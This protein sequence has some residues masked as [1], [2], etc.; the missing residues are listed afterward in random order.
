PSGEAP[1]GFP[2]NVFYRPL[3]GMTFAQITNGGQL[4]QEPLKREEYT[5]VQRSADMAA[6]GWTSQQAEQ[7]AAVIGVRNAKGLLV[8][9][10]W[11]D[12]DS[13]D[14]TR[15]SA[16]IQYLAQQQGIYQIFFNDPDISGATPQQGHGNHIHFSFNFDASVSLPPG[17]GD[18]PTFDQLT[19]GENA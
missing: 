7:N 16:V 18:T 12:K 2:R 14:Q 3:A 8:K 4:L 1:N 13:Y 11:I 6:H 5:K 10:T 9:K 19:L 17:T 15:T